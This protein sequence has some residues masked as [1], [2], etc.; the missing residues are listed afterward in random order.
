MSPSAIIV[1]PRKGF[2]DGY[3]STACRKFVGMLLDYFLCTANFYWDYLLFAISEVKDLPY[4]ARTV[5][6]GFIPHPISSVFGSVYL[7]N[8]SALICKNTYQSV[9][10]LL[11][12]IWQIGV[13]SLNKHIRKNLCV[14]VLVILFGIHLIFHQQSIPVYEHIVSVTHSPPTTRTA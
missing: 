4:L 13:P 9:N 12:R 8:W 14:Q 1:H 3:L 6:V 7:A 5:L 11:V 2:P 10:V